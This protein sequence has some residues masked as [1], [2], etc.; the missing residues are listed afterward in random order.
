MLKLGFCITGSFCS[1]DDM[2]FVL[3]KVS[4]IYDVEVF[5][6]EHVKDL[7]TRFYTH[8]ELTT[9]IEII[10]NKK[11]HTT[12]QEAEVYGPFMHLDIVLI[13][14]CDANTLNKL[15]S[16]INDN[17]VT[18]LVKSSLRNN[19]SIVLGVFSNDVLSYSGQHLFELINKKNYYLVPMY[20]DD[21]KK[22]PFSMIA[23]KNKVLKTLEDALLSKQSQ[24]MILGYKEV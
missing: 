1:M 16:G 22:K 4:E 21:Y 11:C 19:V 15:N 17:A 20:Q 12:L 24:P 23:C 6:S 7:D 18:M 5:L 8:D 13:Y 10:T 14:P 3:K 9:K 2:L